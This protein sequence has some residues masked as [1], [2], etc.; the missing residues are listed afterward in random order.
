MK[1]LLATILVFGL[2]ISGCSRGH[3][4]DAKWKAFEDA[5]DRDAAEPVLKD[6]DH[7]MSDPDFSPENLARLDKQRREEIEKEQ[8]Q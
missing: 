1:K 6:G 2:L 4:N 5:A 3:S 8:K 7:V